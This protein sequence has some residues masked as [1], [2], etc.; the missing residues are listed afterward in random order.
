MEKKEYKPSGKT[1][2]IKTINQLVNVATVDNV[3]ELAKD[4]YVFLHRM[5]HLFDEMRKNHP[6]L[7]KKTNSQI[8][9]SSFIWIDDGKD[10][11]SLRVVIK[12]TGEIA[13]IKPIQ[14][15]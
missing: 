8:A 9:E 2:H 5:T 10:E 4:L 11:E 7:A 6:S 3:D 14:N 13:E 15:L 12:D 1:F